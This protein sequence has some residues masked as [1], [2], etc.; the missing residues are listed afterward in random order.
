MPLLRP[1]LIPGL[2]V[3][4]GRFGEDAA[5]NLLWYADR[6]L[7]GHVG[8]QIKLLLDKIETDLREN[9]TPGLHF[10]TIIP[11]VVEK[12]RDAVT[13]LL[14]DLEVSLLSIRYDMLRTL[15]A[16]ALPDD[17]GELL[18]RFWLRT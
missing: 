4:R 1:E 6:H 7:D 10:S 17:A 13:A 9:R 8:D 14:R 11:L 5:A 2:H 3:V 15:N 18:E 12:H 16:P